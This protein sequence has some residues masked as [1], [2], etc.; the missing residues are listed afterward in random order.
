MQ[1]YS[2]VHVYLFL[3]LI[4]LLSLCAL[5]QERK[6]EHTLHSHSHI[7]FP[8]NNTYCISVH[9]SQLRLKHTLYFPCVLV[10][11]VHHMLYEAKCCLLNNYYLSYLNTM[12]LLFI[13]KK[14]KFLVLTRIESFKM[15]M[16]RNAL[17]YFLEMRQHSVVERALIQS[18]EI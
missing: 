3:V 11:K 16:K 18:L 13:T 6:G 5:I 9:N 2:T 1:H 10:T 17:H 7:M 12:Y 15:I 14:L 8:F 4:F